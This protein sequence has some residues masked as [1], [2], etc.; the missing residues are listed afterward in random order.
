MGCALLMI[1]WQVSVLEWEIN[2]ED[3]IRKP[4]V[5]QKYEDMRPS[6][7]AAMIAFPCESLTR[8]R[9]RPIPGHPNP[10][11]P[12]RNARCVR[13]LPGLS[14]R[15]Q[16]MVDSGN[17]CADWGIQYAIDLDEQG[18]TVLFENPKNSWL[19]KFQQ[20]QAC[21]SRPGWEESE[22]PACAYFSARCK[23]QWAAGNSSAVKRIQVDGCHHLHDENEW[24]P[25]F[26]SA[27]K[28]WVYPS[29]EE[30]E[31]TP[32]LAYTFAIVLTIGAVH[33]GKVKL[34][35]PGRQSC[36]Q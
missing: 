28:V 31:Y 16:A 7:D 33:R 35:V 17:A 15:N 20:M 9:E 1:G 25:Y 32:S 27:A 14:D 8:A 22:Y 12:L 3:D 26:D 5:R 10:P 24:T 29:K 21:L 19:R 2:Q 13:G 36:R 6:L 4:E 11:R 23:W 30:A 18:A 34:A